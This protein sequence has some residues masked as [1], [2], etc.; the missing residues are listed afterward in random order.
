MRFENITYVPIDLDAI[1]PE[2][3]SAKERRELNE[4]HQMVYEKAIPISDRRRKRMVKDLYKTNI[5]K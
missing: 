4:Y 5:K 1:L 3:M 2:E